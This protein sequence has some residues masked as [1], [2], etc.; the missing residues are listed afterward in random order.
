MGPDAKH[1]THVSGIIGAVR[2]TTDG[3]H[4]VLLALRDID[5]GERALA[6]FAVRVPL[7]FRRRIRAHETRRHIVDGDAPGPEF[8]RQ[9][10]RQADLRRLGRGDVGGRVVVVVV[11]DRDDRRADAPYGRIRRLNDAHQIEEVGGR[12]RKMMSWIKPPRM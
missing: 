10:S 8:M 7:A 11:R 2:G 6:F 4:A 12:L 1:G 5:A 9:L 3:K